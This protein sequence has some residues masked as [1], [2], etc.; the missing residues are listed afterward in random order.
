MPPAQ[1]Y[2][3]NNPTP[4]QAPDL[5]QITPPPTPQTAQEP[6]Q[7]QRGPMTN[8]GGIAEVLNSGLKG[9]MQSK[10][11]K[12]LKDYYNFKKQDDNYQSTY[13]MAAQ[14][15]KTLHDSGTDPNSDQYK[16]AVS[17]V[18][19]AWQ[20]LMTFRGQHM[21]I[22]DPGMSGKKKKSKD[23]QGGGDPNNPIAML[24]SNDPQQ[25]LQGAYAMMARLGP[26]VLM[27]LGDPKIAAQ[28]K[29]TAELSAG[30][31]LSEQ[32]RQKEV[33][34]LAAIPASQRTPEQ[35]AR[36]TELTTKPVQPKEPTNAFQGA[37]QAFVE[38]NKRQPTPEEV[39]T[40][41]EKTREGKE[42]SSPF[43]AAAQAKERELGRPLTEKEVYDVY[44]NTKE[45]DPFAQQRADIAQQNLNDRQTKYANQIQ[46]DADKAVAAHK[47]S[48]DARADELQK[49]VD[50]D[51][52]HYTDD[53][54]KKRIQQIE[55]DDYQGMIR[56]GT[57]LAT[58]LRRNGIGAT[59]PMP[60]PWEKSTLD[61]GELDKILTQPELPPISEPQGGETL[62]VP[63]NLGGGKPSAGV[64][65]HGQEELGLPPEIAKQLKP[66]F[67]SNLSDGSRWTMKNGKPFQVSA[68]TQ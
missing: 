50:N 55:R 29:Q 57:N 64:S 28:R 16:Q 47:K 33:N 11:D 24:S 60:K 68:G 22:G 17:A 2:D 39:Y 34:D 1:Q 62:G 4:Y 41:G 26:P 40:M 10:A 31:E 54:Y 14:N 42:P 48:I 7:L 30:N 27:Q 5:P 49:E 35:Q 21:G 38:T 44:H 46:S 13:N 6:A 52:I 19:G 32:Q 58:K 37:Y 15:L 53:D 65:T 12:T 67:I 51:K 25:K 61:K 8:L 59:V 18:Q 45:A 36:Y 9:Y 23:S 66:G 20:G 3:P 56:I 43:A 63:N